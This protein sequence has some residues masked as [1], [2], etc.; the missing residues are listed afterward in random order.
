M[1]RKKTTAQFIA[2]ARK[3]HGDKYDYSKVDY[4]G[5]HEY[6]TIICPEHGEFR[7]RPNNHLTMKQGCPKCGLNNNAKR[8]RKGYDYFLAE[9]HKV[10][11][12]KFDYSKARYIDLRTKIEICCPTHGC[13]MQSPTVHLKTL[14][15]PKCGREIVSAKRKGNSE[16]F[17]N[18]AIARF[19][20]LYDYS[21]V[22]YINSY[23]PVEIVCRRH[24]PFKMLTYKHLNGD[25][26]PLCQQNERFIASAKKVHGDKY[27]YSKVEYLDVET[28]V[29]IT[30]PIHGDFLQRPHLHLKGSGCHK[31]GIES[32]TSLRRNTIEVFLKEARAVHGDEYDYSKVQYV[33]CDTPVTIV[34]RVHGPFKQSPYS[35]NNLGAGCP[36]CG[37][38]RRGAEKRKTTELFIQQAKLVHGDKYDYS[39]VDYDGSGAK[40]RIICPIHGEFEQVANDHIKGIGCRKCYDDSKRKPL[41]ELIVDFNRIHKGKYSYDKV[42]YKNVKTKITVTCPIHGDFLTRPDQHLE[43]YG[44]HQCAILE[45]ESRLERTIREM[46][47][48]NELVF[49]QEKAFS[50]LRAKNPLFLDFFL[51]DYSVAIECQG[52]QHFHACDFYG[53]VS[54]YRITK[55][56]DDLKKRLCEEHGIRILYYS[57]L[58]IE[59]PYFVIEDLGQLLEAIIEKGKVDPSRWKDPELPLFP[60]S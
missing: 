54:S 40:V 39:L 53:G 35:H 26:C 57:N 22:N 31:C 14:G 42:V 5:V 16:V 47:E 24:G 60:L 41:S 28:P 36:L 27:D 48:I 1:P 29:V 12:N 8:Q 46:L 34:C 56:R 45:S 32:R 15:C 4:A 37:A 25:G 21:N 44:C 20:E 18:K 17:I 19:G 30:C 23:T 50:W 33:N 55:H 9:A 49:E 2:D 59:Y 51:P 3:V 13:Y 7:Q 38:S 43:G 10:H 6:V 52:E 11:G 58:G